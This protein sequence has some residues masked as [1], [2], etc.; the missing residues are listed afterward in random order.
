M[1]A[2]VSKP[3]AA[4]LQIGIRN[5]RVEIGV[6]AGVFVVN[7]THTGEITLAEQPCDAEFIDETRFVIQCESGTSPNGVFFRVITVTS[8]HSVQSRSNSKF[9]FVVGLNE[10]PPTTNCGKL[11]EALEEVDD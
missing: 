7:V 10:I 9:Q 8:F 4:E 11:M 1:L 6:R 5:E 2:M 3:D